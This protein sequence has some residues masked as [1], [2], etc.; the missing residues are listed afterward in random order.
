MDILQTGEPTTVWNPMFINILIVNVSMN[1][2]QFMMNTLIPKY[3]DFLG[4]SPATVG[5]VASIFTVTALAIKPVSGP[6][7]DTYPKKKVLFAAICIILTAFVIYSMAYSL[8]TVIIARLIHGMGMGFTASTCL[9][10]A[11]E[12]LPRDKLTQGIGYFSLGQALIS[13]AGPSIGLALSA[14]YGYNT[15]F[16]ICAMMMAISATLVIFMKTPPKHEVKAFKITWEGMFAKEAI[17][18]AT[19]QLFL[20]MSYTTINSFLVLYAQQGRGVENIGLWFTCNAIGLLVSRPLLGK[21]GDRYGIHRIMPPAFAMFA[22]S[23]LIISFSTNIYWFLLSAIIGAWGYGA[24]MPANQAL[25]MKCVTPERRGVGGNTNYI[26]MDFGA[27]SGPVIAGILV[28]HF[29]Y[30]VMYRIMI[31]PI[32]IAAL[33]FYLCYPKIKAICQR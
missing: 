24:I 16:A 15:T 1:F 14:A 7:I 29:G 32:A 2:G 18:P 28:T 31:F 13:A 17:I 33:F 11:S 20:A 3:A 30:S 6:V 9:S 10:I 21:L 8:T 27:F 19:L 22:I 4:A 5:L 25:C 26:G 12:A 23:L